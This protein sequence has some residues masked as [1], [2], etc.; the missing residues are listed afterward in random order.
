MLA[1]FNPQPGDIALFRSDYSHVAMVVGYDKETGELEIMEGNR[2][3]K[4]QATEYLTGDNQITFLGRFND[5]DYEPGGKVDSDLAAA[6][7]PAVSHTTIG[8]GAGTR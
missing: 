7:D 6:K 2:S 1:D 8:A 3:N 5:S 4:V